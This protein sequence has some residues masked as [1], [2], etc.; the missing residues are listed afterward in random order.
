MLGLFINALELDLLLS[1]CRRGNRTLGERPL[2]T[3]AGR[4]QSWKLSLGVF[5]PSAR[6]H[7][8]DAHVLMS[9]MSLVRGEAGVVV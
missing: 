1:S 3:P 4:N 6:L 8:M 5:E 7:S 2:M 9:L